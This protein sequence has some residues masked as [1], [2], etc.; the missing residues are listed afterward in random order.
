M[1]KTIIR[2][3]FSV[4]LAITASCVGE[5]EM[6]D[7][8]SGNFEALWKIMDEH[9]CFFPEKKE[10]LGVDWNEVYAKYKVR[11]QKELP[12]E[13][14]FEVLG[15]ML[16]ELR[17]GHVNMSSSFDYARNWSWK[18]DYPTNL[19]DTLLRKYLGTDYRIASGMQYRILDD[20][21]GYIRCG[22]FATDFG[23][24]NIDEVLYYLAPCNGLI[25]DIRSNGGGMMTSAE[26]LATRFTH[27]ET[28][29]G[30]IR[31]TTGKGHEDFSEMYEQRIK[32]SRRITWEK[33]VVVLTNRGVYSAA[34]E[35]TK[36]M[37]ALGAKTVGDTTG[38]GAGMPFSSEL[39]N[40][41]ALRFSA[42]P[43]Y[44]ADKK[45]IE[46]GIA[47]D[48]RVSLTDEDTAK[49]VDTIIEY[50]RGMMR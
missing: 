44:D 24:G 3:L 19:S 46:E 28:I 15:D 5:E 35:F 50:A 30:Y 42:C 47:P 20:N 13:Q 18:E 9:Y 40:G 21:I 36:Y 6:P 8:T 4:V 32:P 34:N 17:D 33:D 39:P 25:I 41:W 43:T 16:G 29:V 48:V 10:Q 23:E 38:G 49:G 27:K 1:R 45:C 7:T 22:S 14:L 26:K 37:K 2:L 31:H 12:A 11:T